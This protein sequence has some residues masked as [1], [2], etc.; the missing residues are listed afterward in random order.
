VRGKRLDRWDSPPSSTF[1]RLRIYAAPKQDPRPPTC[2]YRKA[3]TESMRGP[4]PEISKRVTDVPLKMQE[5]IVADLQKA[6][7]G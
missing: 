6:Y 4:D 5:I 1:F 3:L 2:Q 7:G